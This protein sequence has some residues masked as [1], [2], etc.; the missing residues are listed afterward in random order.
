MLS[1]SSGSIIPSSFA[2][3]LSLSSMIGNANSPLGTNEHLSPEHWTLG[4]L[5][6]CKSYSNTNLFQWYSINEITLIHPWWLSIE[7]QDK[8]I[9]FVFLLVNSGASLAARDNS[10]VQTGV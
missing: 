6:A 7:S 3:F 5:Y 9:N 1:N 8:P 2:N 4:P 10:V